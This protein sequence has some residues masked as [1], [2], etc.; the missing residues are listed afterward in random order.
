MLIGCSELDPIVYDAFSLPCP[1]KLRSLTTH[2]QEMSTHRLEKQVKTTSLRIQNRCF[3]ASQTSALTFSYM[4]KNRGTVCYW[5]EG[6]PSV[7]LACSVE[8][9]QV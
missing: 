5:F 9:W 4:V 6:L 2:S 7:F 3:L 1:F 8:S